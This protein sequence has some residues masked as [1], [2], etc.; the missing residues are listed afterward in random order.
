MILK[1]KA[2]LAGRVK[3]QISGGERGTIDYD[4]FDNMILDQGLRK[5]LTSFA[6]ENHSQQALFA[7]G[8]GSSS[9]AVE[10]TDTDLIS[11]IKRLFDYGAQT[12]G[13]DAAGGFG[14][15]RNVKSFARGAAAGNISELTTGWGDGVNQAFARAL[16]RDSS[17]NPA[18]ITV[19]SDEV[20]TVTWEIRRWWTSKEPH[21]IFYSKDGVDFET[22]V[23][24]A[25]ESQFQKNNSGLGSGGT[26]GFIGTMTE[27]FTSQRVVFFNENLGNPQIQSIP[28]LIGRVAN[29]NAKVNGQTIPYD[30]VFATFTPAISKTYEFTVS[31][32]LQLTL[33]RRGE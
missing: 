30:A 13:W 31:I 4:W 16:V 5:L 2:E 25:S 24:Y 19:L 17:G 12:Y 33:S 26:A 7:F 15:S 22:V 23:S 21:S 14:W 8:V 29:P 1:H 18:T 9:Q 20:L 28:S 27:D 10:P 11:P 6:S 32:T 3:L